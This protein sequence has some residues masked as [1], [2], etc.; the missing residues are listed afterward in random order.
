MA[1]GA[2][3]TAA[4]NLSV[5]W[6]HCCLKALGLE[7]WILLEEPEE[8]DE[9]DEQANPTE[10]ESD[11][12]QQQQ[13]SLRQS[14]QIINL[15]PDRHPK[16][17]TSTKENKSSKEVLD[18]WMAT[19]LQIQSNLQTMAHWMKQKHGDYV[20]LEMSDE[21]ATLIQSTVT[22]F[23]ATT[24]NEIESLHACL[25]KQSQQQYA[26]PQQYKQHCSGI[27]QILM[28]QLQQDIAEPW[29]RWQ[30]LRHRT[31]VQLWQ[32]PLQC[33]LWTAVPFK[34]KTNRNSNNKPTTL[35]L[36]GLDDDDDDGDD[37][38]KQQQQRTGRPLDQHFYPQ[39]PSHVL[40]RHFLDSYQ[41][42]SLPR[43][44]PPGF[45]ALM[46]PSGSASRSELAST[47]RP[48]RPKTSLQQ[49]QPL[50]RVALENKEDP[51]S[52]TSAAALEEESMLLQSTLLQ[53]HGDLDS[54]QHLEQTMV[55]ITTLLSQ[56]ANLVAEQQENVWDIADSAVTTKE[57]M[58][59]GQEN[60]QQATE[61]TAASRHLLAQGIVA[62]ACLLLLLNWL[63]A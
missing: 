12:A 49:Q 55:D 33:R 1:G 57:N 40:H 5:N 42:L 14:F 47:P 45:V 16:P 3:F 59:Q 25:K 38:H 7:D 27:V 32:T 54:V 48:T 8:Y 52:A 63:V 6:R 28:A 15:I 18:P 20:S 24:A 56:F 39:R 23:T 37:I 10:E 9:D 50:R 58:E 60:L 53:Q 26:Q 22:S 35:E 46:G 41:P 62:M 19:A 4:D 34:K 51:W 17:N 44:K 2:A 21:E 31:A 36:L 13:Q 61:A 11:N 43:S 30:K 29:G